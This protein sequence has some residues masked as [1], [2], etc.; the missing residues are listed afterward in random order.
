MG[1]GVGPAGAQENAT[2]ESEDPL[3]D[4]G[5][6]IDDRV[7]LTDWK[8]EDGRFVLEFDAELSTG[9]QVTPR[10]EA[11]EG[12]VQI[13]WVEEMVPRGGGTIEVPA[14][15]VSGEASV[16]IS[17]HRSR[18]DRRAV[19]VS[20]GTVEQNPFGYFGGT[21]GLFAGVGLSIV[22]AGGA[23]AFVFWRENDDVVV[24]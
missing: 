19:R 3:G 4:R 16:Q 23:T 18:A 10:Q 24:A 14:E 5:A 22:A 6:I 8:Y 1:M 7:T 13:S 21:T 17:T 12:A 15:K 9:V 20:T 2:N 11:G